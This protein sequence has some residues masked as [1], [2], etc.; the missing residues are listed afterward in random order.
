MSGLFTL[1]LGT[2]SG[3]TRI[4]TQ[5]RFS[6]ELQL[7]LIE[8]YKVTYAINATHQM[9]LLQKS[10]EIKAADL[11]SVKRLMVGGSAIPVDIA[12]QLA[13][14][15]PNGNVISGYGMTQ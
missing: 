11:S 2:F 5:Q 6:P 1:L 3:A 14:H 15:L 12:L 10:E 4:I 9:V 8:R 13:K 7:R